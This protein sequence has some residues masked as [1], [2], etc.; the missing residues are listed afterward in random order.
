MMKIITDTRRTHSI[1][2]FLLI[3]KPQRMSSQ[4]EGDPVTSYSILLN[5]PINII[6][7]HLIFS[8]ISKQA[9]QT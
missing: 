6:S 3:S 4:T 5:Q 9:I 8:K 2:L 1:Y 7:D